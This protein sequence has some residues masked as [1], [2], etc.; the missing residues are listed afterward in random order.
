MYKAL[1]LRDYVD[2]LYIERIIG[3]RGL[4]SIKDCID[5]TIKRF[6]IIQE[7]SRKY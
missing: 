1:Y 5:Y 3:G 7:R 6:K 2:S 4:I